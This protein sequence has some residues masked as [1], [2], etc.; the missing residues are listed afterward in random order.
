[1]QFSVIIPTCHRNDLHM[2]RSE[3]DLRLLGGVQKTEA[4]KLCWISQQ[5]MSKHSC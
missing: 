1:M 2:A 3:I 5:I 4:E